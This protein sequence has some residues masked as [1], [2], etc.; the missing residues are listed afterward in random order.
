MWTRALLSH[1]SVHILIQ[2][3]ELVLVDAAHKLPPNRYASCICC[4]DA[5]K[6]VW[7]KMEPALIYPIALATILGQLTLATGSVYGTLLDHWKPTPPF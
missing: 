1:S 2:E 3:I 5:A 6:E 4:G 7:S